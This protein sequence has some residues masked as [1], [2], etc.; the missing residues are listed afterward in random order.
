[1]IVIYILIFIFGL[2][3]GSFI[4]VVIYRLPKGQNFVSGRSRCPKCRKIL[5]WYDLIPLA[6][7]LILG[8]KCRYCGKKISWSYFIIELSSGILFLLSFIRLAGEGTAH[9]LMALF[10]L[11][12]FLILFMTDLKYLILPDKIIFTALGAILIF[13]VLER[14]NIIKTTFDFIT[15]GSIL[16]AIFLSFLVFFFWY[17]SK[18]KW[19]GLGDSKLVALI[20]LTFGSIGGIMVIYIAIIVGALVGLALLITKRANMKTKLP[21]GSFI[22]LSAIL[23]FF[24]GDVIMKLVDSTGIFRGFFNF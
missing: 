15:I 24:A 17:I 21:L 12:V 10:L 9:W 3:I 16:T 18:G 4:N 6:S 22:C 20:G 11:E 2:I 13:G 8:G 5:K 23:Y 14:L 1:M 7:F 19:I